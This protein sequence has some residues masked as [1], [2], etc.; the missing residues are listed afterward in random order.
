VDFLLELDYFV[1]AQTTKKIKAMKKQAVKKTA[2]FC[3]L[4]LLVSA[5]LVCS[6][7]TLL[8]KFFIGNNPLRLKSFKIKCAKC[9]RE[10]YDTNI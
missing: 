3:S 4:Y 10:K 7:I 5:F 8:S 2:R 9:I 6:G 1:K